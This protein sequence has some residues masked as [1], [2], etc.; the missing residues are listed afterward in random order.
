MTEQVQSFSIKETK[1]F[2][3]AIFAVAA[4]LVERLKD[5]ADLDD[6]LAVY[7][8]LTK[9]TEFLAVITAAYEGYK[10]IP[11]EIKDIDLEEGF[12]EKQEQFIPR[13]Q[14]WTD[15]TE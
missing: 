10:L 8:K 2:A 3:V 1:E 11:S 4:L 6:V 14:D 5:G 7:E 13:D 9:D 15:G 12:I